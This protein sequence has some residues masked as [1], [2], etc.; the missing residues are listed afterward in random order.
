MG[1]YVIG[2]MAGYV[3]SRCECKLR[4]N[5]FL[6]LFLW[7]SAAGT[8]MGALYGLFHAS[9][10]HPLTV[11]VAAFY[12]AV[13]RTVWGACVAW[14]VIACC[15][16]NGGFVDTVLSWSGLVPLSRL[17]YCI[18]LLHIM[19]MDLYMMNQQ[20]LFYM[21]DINI[22]MFFLGILVVSYMAAFVV[23]LAFEAPMMGL[24][25]ILFRRGSESAKP[26][27][28][29]KSSWRHAYANGAANISETKL[30]N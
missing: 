10:G 4:I 2:L 26:A 16:G 6:N 7:L 1:P 15:T 11:E 13:H 20:S 24:E 14:V 12:S 8:A 9:K 27:A 30:Y 25:K 19:V 3:L 18:Y 17:T 5:K 22:V 21:S 28:K 29:G 23:S